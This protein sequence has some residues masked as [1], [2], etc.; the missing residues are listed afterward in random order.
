MWAGKGESQEWSARVPSLAWRGDSGDTQGGC[1]PSDE[2][3]RSSYKNLG[4]ARGQRCH[5]GWINPGD[6]ISRLC[7]SGSS[8]DGDSGDIRGDEPQVSKCPGPTCF[9]I[10]GTARGQW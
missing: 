10:L 6:Q 4:T 1:T 5:S 9:N 3:S 8:G 7:P 2:V